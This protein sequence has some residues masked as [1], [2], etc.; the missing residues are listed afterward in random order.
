MV[1]GSGSG[2]GVGSTAAQQAQLA[3]GRTGV[4]S[5]AL[6]AAY[7]QASKPE[8]GVTETHDLIVLS[9]IR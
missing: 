8:V 9:S 5:G 2:T 4:D 3:S 6:A 7:Q 1:T